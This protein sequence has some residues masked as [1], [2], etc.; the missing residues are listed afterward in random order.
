MMYHIHLMQQVND[1]WYIFYFSSSNH[2][3]ICLSDIEQAVEAC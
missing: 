2:S 3:F 1:T